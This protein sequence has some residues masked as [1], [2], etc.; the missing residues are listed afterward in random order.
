MTA[1]TIDQLTAEAHKT[2]AL[3]FVD[4]TPAADHLVAYYTLHHGDGTDTYLGRESR[5]AMTA[6]RAR[7]MRRA[8]NAERDA[9]IH[10]T[11]ICPRCAH[12]AARIDALSRYDNATLICSPCGTDEALSDWAGAVLPGPA[13]WP[14]S[15][16]D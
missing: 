1:Y 10:T 14:V 7:T 5:T 6:L 8:I 2:D 15:M 16:P 13:E 11:N 4:Y 9:A 3:A 12:A